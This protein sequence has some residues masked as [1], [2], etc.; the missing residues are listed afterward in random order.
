[1]ALLNRDPT[2]TSPAV[3]GVSDGELVV[4]VQAGDM[5]AFDELFQRHNNRLCTYLVVSPKRY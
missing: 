1:M 2:T 3:G 4:R 5:S